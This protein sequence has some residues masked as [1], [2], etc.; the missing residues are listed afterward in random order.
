MIEDISRLKETRRILHS[1]LDK[2][3]LEDLNYVPPGFSNSIVWNI[4]HCVVTF[5][6]LS[7]GL[8]K[9]TIPL[10]SFWLDNFGKGTKHDFD[11][12]G[13]QITELKKLCFST[14][15]E[16]KSDFDKGIFNEFT[17]YSTSYNIELKSIEDA[18]AFNNMHEAL[19]LG[20][21]MAQRKVK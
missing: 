8:S 21:I 9:L 14:I 7:Y 6:K 1:F 11:L 20:Y 3:T 17:I 5:A 10:D 19:H 18:I 4:A 2:T 13:T 12:D 16:F 15:E